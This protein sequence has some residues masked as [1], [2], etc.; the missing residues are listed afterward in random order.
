VDKDSKN[1]TVQRSVSRRCVC[2]NQSTYFV[3]PNVTKVNLAVTS[4]FNYDLIML[5]EIVINKL[6]LFH[7]H[8]YNTLTKRSKIINHLCLMLFCTLYFKYKLT[9]AN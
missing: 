2:A 7:D 3:T 8:F 5:N 1:A 6:L 9:K 4:K